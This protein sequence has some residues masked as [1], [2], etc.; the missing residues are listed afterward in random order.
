[1]KKVDIP[2]SVPSAKKSEY[3]KNMRLLTGDSGN[4][5]LIAG[6]QKIEHLNDDFFGPKI[7]KDDAGPRHLFNIASKSNGGAL[8]AQL[9]LISRFGKE[10]PKLPYIVKINSKTNI[11]E[12]SLKDSSVPLW[13]VKDVLSFKKA[14]G[15]KIAAIGYTIYLG[16]QHE[17]K[18]LSEASKAIFEAHQNGLVAIIWMY[19][20]AKGIKE[21]SIHTIAGGAGVATCLDADF[22]KVKYPYQLKDKKKTA[23]K[24]QEVTEAAGKTK[25]ICAGGG[26]Q[27]AKDVLTFLDL[28]IKHGHCHGVAIGRNLH[29]RDIEEASRLAKAISAMLIKKAS[30]KEALKILNNKKKVN[31]TKKSNS[32]ILGLF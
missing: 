21:E 25:V 28:Q 19:P 16:H 30:L 3:L 32:K 22:V 11:G 26:K 23:D 15:L 13:S 17:A 18:M 29:Q 27:V 10:Y 8:A 1:M 7:S 5:F 14:S 12:D 31:K 24:F 4:L 2:A 6:D 9:G 20:R